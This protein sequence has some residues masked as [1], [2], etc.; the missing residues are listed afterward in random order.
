MYFLVTD[1]KA[2]NGYVCVPCKTT[3]LTLFR[4]IIGTLS[5]SSAVLDVHFIPSEDLGSIFGVATSTGSIGIYEVVQS[6]GQL[7]M[8]EHVKTIQYFPENVLIT[9]F[10]WHPETPAVGMTLS[11]GKVCLGIV[12]LGEES[13]SPSHIDIGSHDLEA[14]T[15]AF[16][17]NGSGLYSGGDDSALKFLETSDNP[18]SVHQGAPAISGRMPW[19]DKKIHGAGVT[20]ILPIAVDEKSSLIVTGSYDDHIRLVH[21]PN[22]GR[23]QVLAEMN[24]GGGVWRLKML[25]RKPVLPADWDSSQSIPRPDEVTL[26]VSCMHAGTRIVKLVRSSEEDWQFEVLGMFQR[27]KSMNYGSDCRPEL[28]AKGQRTFITT[29][30]YDRLMCLWRF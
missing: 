5:T 27:H 14:W 16:L 11:T 10:S 29:S 30:F 2:G 25:E 19:T 3:I 4:E 20:A 7:P 8:I 18:T 17:P 23:R 12:D 26:L 28:N 24:L 13:G 6:H 22:A 9:A 15:L 1:F 21:V